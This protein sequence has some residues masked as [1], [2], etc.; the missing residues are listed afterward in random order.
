MSD[1]PSATP[2]APSA[3]PGAKPSAVASTDT[4]AVA[5]TEPSV[6]PP[7]LPLDTLDFAKGNGLVTVVT[8]DADFD[9]IARVCPALS[10]IK[11]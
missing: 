8:Q 7:H 9:R 5:S 11:I 2:T 4:P 6:I 3:V 1:T 10:V